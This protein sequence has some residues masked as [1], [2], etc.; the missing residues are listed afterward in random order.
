MQKDQQPPRQRKPDDASTFTGPMKPLAHGFS[1]GELLDQQSLPSW[2]GQPNA[3]PGAP[4]PTNEQGGQRGQAGFSAS[5]LLD[6]NALPSWLQESGQGK[7][8]NPASPSQAVPPPGSMQS[9]QPQQTWQPGSAAP[10]GGSPTNMPMGSGLSASSFLDRDSLPGWLTGA[11]NQLPAADPRQASS[12]IARPGAF[13]EQQRVENVRVPSRPRSEIHASQDSEVAANVFASML[14]VASAPNYPIQQPNIQIP[15]PRQ[16]GGQVPPFPAQMPQ[17]QSGPPANPF[18]MPNN[19]PQ[20]QTSS[21]SLGIPQGIPQNTPY[22]APQ[23]Q[24]PSTSL[25]IPQNAP[26]G[27]GQGFQQGTP[28]QGIGLGQPSQPM[29]LYP[30]GGQSNIYPPQGNVPNNYYTM[31]SPAAGMPPGMSNTPSLQ[32]MP[33]GEPRPEAKPAKRG[34]FNAIRDWL[35]PSR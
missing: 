1:A 2:M 25:G 34:L 33:N 35:S 14:G 28:Q 19:A 3:Q 32:Q 31:G 16:P 11:A 20:P 22:G 9:P 8:V 26:Y 23:P 6:A 17:P 15:Q 10:S 21:T 29:P 7:K 30:Q 24:T 12:G 27:M 5:S 18:A 4:A 13:G